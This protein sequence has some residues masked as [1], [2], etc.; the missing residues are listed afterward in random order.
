VATYSIVGGSLE[1]TFVILLLDSGGYNRAASM[2]TATAATATRHF[3]VICICS[4]G[5]ELKYI[6]L[7]EC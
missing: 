4:G 7:S 3:Y 1:F 5:R 6:T 2:A